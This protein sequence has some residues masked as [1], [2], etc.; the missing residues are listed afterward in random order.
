M[1]AKAIMRLK[2]KI[3]KVR[4]DSKDLMKNKDIEREHRS[5]IRKDYLNSLMP[6]ERTPIPERWFRLPEVFKL[7]KEL[8]WLEPQH[9]IRYIMRDTGIKNRKSVRILMDWCDANGDPEQDNHWLEWRK[10]YVK[11]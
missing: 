10:A 3:H 11:T 1:R 5:K 2:K 4:I 6:Y 7:N 8:D 9:R